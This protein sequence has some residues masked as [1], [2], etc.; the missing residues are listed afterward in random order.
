MLVVRTYVAASGI[1]GAGVFLAEPV[2][3]GQV[4][5]RFDPIIDVEITEDQLASLPD[6]ARETAMMHAFLNH[7]GRMILSRDNAVFFNHSE[8][9]T[10]LNDGDVNIAARDLPV[11][12]E[13]SEDYRQSFP[14]GACSEF[15]RKHR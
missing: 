4:V 2:K 13:L 10:T 6:G 3:S 12:T 14:I 1:H 8:H 5:W 15:L 9:P 7:D 11:D